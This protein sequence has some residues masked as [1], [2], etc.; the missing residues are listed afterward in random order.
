MT[1]FKNAMVYLDDF[2]FHR[3]G[4][5]VE[6]GR[7]SAIGETDD[8]AVDLEGAYVIPGL[9][10]IHGHG[11]SGL[12][13][14]DA[15]YDDMTRMAAYLAEN[16]ITAFCATSMT[17]PEQEIAS[18]YQVVKRFHQ[19]P[20]AQVSRLAG[21]N[22]E[23]PFFSME[24]RGAHN[25]THLHSPD[26]EMLY[27]LN[28]V[29][30]GLLR[31][32]DIAPELEGALPFIKEASKLCTVSIAHTAATYDQAKA[33]FE[34]G[35]THVTH[36]FNA[37][38]SLLH[39]DPGVI[40]A[41]SENP[42][43]RAELICDGI[44]VHESAVRAAFRLFGADRICLISDALSVCGMPNGEYPLGDQTVTLKDNVARL[45]SGTIAGAATNLFQGMKNA[46]RF[47]IS[48]EDAIRT[49]TYNPACAIHAEDE[50]GSIAAGKY[51]DFV[52]CD[53]AFTLQKVYLGGVEITVN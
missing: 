28:Q 12:D 47:G 24:K 6:K 9:I 25:P 26:L 18:S 21:I 30:G 29:C 22:M 43:V 4:F 32:I 46:M 39:R 52:V 50:I 48:P 5:T 17:L 42:H 16:G 20:P 49:A 10:D 1:Q 13:F 40:G 36:L 53:P 31:L 15:S 23:G 19:E 14:S 41:A 44:H 2:Q 38:P 33:G 34:A 51:A 3:T 8:G 37:M 11:N 45:Q 7:F 35:A 27:R